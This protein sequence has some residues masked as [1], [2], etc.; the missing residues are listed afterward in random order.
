MG[1]VAGATGGFILGEKGVQK[2]ME[3]F[4]LFGESEKKTEV[5]KNL[6]E[7]KKNNDELTRITRQFQEKE[8][9]LEESNQFSEKQKKIKIEDLK[10]D[11]QKKTTEI[12]EQQQLLNKKDKMLREGKSLEVIKKNIKVNEKN[13]ELLERL[14]ENFKEFKNRMDN[15]RNNLGNATVIGGTNNIV[16]NPSQQTIVMDTNIKDPF[17]QHHL[18]FT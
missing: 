5:Q 9:L 14:N 10:A 16:S 2:L 13:N 3:E 12:R 18:S 7:M 15:L 11:L 4:K 17:A 6:E 1:S 8:R